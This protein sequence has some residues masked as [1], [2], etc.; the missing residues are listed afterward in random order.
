MANHGLRSFIARLGMFVALSICAVLVPTV[1][2]ADVNTMLDGNPVLDVEAS[3]SL[4][5]IA[6]A[7]QSSGETVG[8]RG[9]A[10]LAFGSRALTH[11]LYSGDGFTLSP[12]SARS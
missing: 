9:P 5:S 3:L 7:A 1:S 12:D 4:D 6:H 11:D 8:P 10:F 2:F